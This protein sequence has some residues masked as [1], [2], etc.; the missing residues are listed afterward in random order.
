MTLK[1]PLVAG[2]RFP[3]QS[4]AGVAVDAI[5]LTPLVSL[6]L[7]GEEGQIVRLA[8]DGLLYVWRS[9]VWEVDSGSGTYTSGSPT[10]VTIGGIPAGS[11][12]VETPFQ[13][14]WEQLLHPYQAP[15]FTSFS[16]NHPSVVEVGYTIPVNVSFSWSTSNSGNIQTNS[17]SLTDVTGGN[18]LLASGLANDGSEALTL[19]ST[20]QKTTAT[21]HQFRA[22]GTN[23]NAVGFLTTTT[24]TWLWRQFYGVQ[25]AA[26]LSESQIEAL[27][28]TS[29]AT[30]YAGTY[31]TGGGGYK[32]VCFANAA[33]GQINTVK[34]QL[35]GFN[36]PMA[37]SAPYSNVDG[38]GFNYALVSVTNVNGITTNYR[39][40]RTANSLGGAI[41]LVVT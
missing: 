26:T 27:A 13:D 14:M 38:G 36:V 32:Y 7:T 1:P 11:V 30:G 29:L 37:V 3:E 12:F 34:D 33:G 20:I 40:Y 19:G 15:G 39:V 21:T 24:I 8:T 16:I 18:T 35:T 31:A 28:G 2:N 5:L 41:T 25:A 17:I 4:K 9:G 6:P 10:T 23:T 22:N